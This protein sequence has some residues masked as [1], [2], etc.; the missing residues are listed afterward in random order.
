MQITL[1]STPDQA[2]LISCISTFGKAAFI[3]CDIK[4][5]GTIERLN[6]TLKKK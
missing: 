4:N 5:H 6:E 3:H 1:K 2:Q